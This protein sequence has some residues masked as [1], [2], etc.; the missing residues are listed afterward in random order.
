MLPGRQRQQRYFLDES[1]KPEND[2]LAQYYAGE[3]TTPADGM[4]TSARAVASGD[5]EFSTALDQLLSA[6][7]RM[8]GFPDDVESLEAD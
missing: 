4:H 8:F 7:G 6:H 3:T 5:L 1:L 2:G